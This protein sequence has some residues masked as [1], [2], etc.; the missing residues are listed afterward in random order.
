MDKNNTK[1]VFIFK[2]PSRTTEG[3]KSYDYEKIFNETLIEVEKGK[4]RE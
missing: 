3:R 2:P 4:F 1:T